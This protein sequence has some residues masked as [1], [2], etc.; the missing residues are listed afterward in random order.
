[1]STTGRL[2]VGITFAYMAELPASPI[3]VL[4]LQLGTPDSTEVS[5]VRKYLRE[6]LSDPRVLDMPA[7]AR[8]LLLNAIILPF[9][10]KKSAEAYEKVW[11]EEGSPLTV[12]TE[13]LATK[14]QAALGDTYRV[15]YGMRYQNPSIESAVVELEKAGCREI[16]LLPQFPQY[17]SASGGS[18]VQKALEVIGARRNVP[19]VRGVGPFFDDPGF[20]EAAAGIARPLL[21]EFAP[22]HVVFSYHGLP[23]KQIRKSDLSGD[24]CLE[25]SWCCD[26]MNEK[27]VFCYRAQCFATTRGLISRLGIDGSI[28]STAFQ[29]RL[30]GQKWIEPYTDKELPKLFA[31]GVRRLAVLTP[32]FTADCLETIEE[33]GIRGRTQWE[34]LGGEAFLLVPCVNADDRW[35]AAV[36]DMARAR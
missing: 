9:R 13:A 1:M 2:L 6:F 17:A 32:S 15:V 31:A 12:Y 34:E 33:I 5:D 14:L 36:A 4:L 8:T 16:V 20:L 18:A 19:E 35:V 22:D 28:T 3:G 30:A 26:A 23:E 25:N 27:N 11:T 29:S 10:P 21:A 7:L 24:W